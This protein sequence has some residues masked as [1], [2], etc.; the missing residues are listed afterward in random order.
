MA[1][2]PLV[3]INIPT[4]APL[5][6]EAIHYFDKGLFLFSYD[7]QQSLESLRKLLSLPFRD[8]NKLWKD[9]KSYRRELIENFV[10]SSQS[11]SHKDIIKD[12]IN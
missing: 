7:K 5:K 2:T 4:A 9:K 6:K 12:C 11:L 1:D 10:S 3:F 8:I